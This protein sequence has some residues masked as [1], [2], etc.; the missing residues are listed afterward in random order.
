MKLAVLAML[1]CVGAV[2]AL[3]L[4][5]P[6]ALPEIDATAQLDVGKLANASYRIDVP[7]RWNGALIVFYHGYALEP[8]VFERGEAISPMFTPMLDAGYAVLQSG[9]SAGGWAVEQGYADTDAL[10][11]YFVAH[12]GAPKKTYAM[13]MSMGGALTVLT[14]ENKPQVYAGAL[15][16]CGAIEPSDRLMQRDLA[17]R[18]AFDFYFPGTLG[19]L[20]PVSDEMAPDSERRI[21]AALA[22]RP[23]ATQALL[24]W[25]GAA[26]PQNLP[27]V[28]GFVAHEIGEL[29]RRA[30]GLPVGNADTIYV[31][32]GDDIA[33]NAGVKRYRA[34]PAAAQYLARWYTPSGNLT[35]PL[36]AL[37]DSGDPLVPANSANEY[38]LAATRTGH[39]ANFVQQY[40][41]R[42]GHCVFT[43]AEIGKAFDA[44]VTWSEGGERPAAG[45]VR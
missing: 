3:A 44:M 23:D 9:Y 34:N 16:L 41:A 39:G 29:Q 5:A 26:T 27:G 2:P 43:P 30:H 11:R 6:A 33:L 24:R 12:Y 28:I 13:G 22:R 14:I 4:A 7:P 35:R 10:R 15:S 25:Y 18:A 40:V 20:D 36:L 19:T 45:L 21:A 38:A 31:G 37:H 17:L 1:L 42:E 32:S 8:I